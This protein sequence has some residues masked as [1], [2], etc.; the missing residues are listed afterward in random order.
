MLNILLTQSH[1]VTLS[2][3]CAQIVTRFPKLVGMSKYL[4]TAPSLT[5]GTRWKC[6]SLFPAALHKFC[7]QFY[8][9]KISQLT[10]ATV[11]LSPLST[12]LIIRTKWVPKENQLIGQGG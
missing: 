3:T 11:R 12:A 7:M 10:D 2:K 8:S 4:S 5:P 6:I 9:P 1:N